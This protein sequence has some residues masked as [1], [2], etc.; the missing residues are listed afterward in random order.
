M[1][2]GGG[3]DLTALCI[4]TGKICWLIFVDALVLNMDG[5]VA[6]ALSIATRVSPHALCLLC[7]WQPIDNMQVTPVHCL[8]WKGVHTSMTLYSPLSPP[9]LTRYAQPLPVFHICS[10]WYRHDHWSFGSW[11]PQAVDV[12]TVKY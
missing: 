9:V 1:H 7:T 6:D 5:N 10:S 12:N 3:L 11:G 8:F 4:T 2:A